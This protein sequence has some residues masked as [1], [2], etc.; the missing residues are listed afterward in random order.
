MGYIG[1]GCNVYVYP[2]RD[3]NDLWQYNPKTNTWQ[4]MASFPG[5]GR[6]SPAIFVIGHKAFVVTGAND[7]NTDTCYKGCW[8]Y[9]AHTNAWTQKADFPGAA[10]AGAVGFAIGNKGYMGMG[11]S[12]AYNAY[13]DFWEY[14][15]TTDGWI[16]KADFGGLARQY[17]S[18][19]GVNDKGY[20][21]FGEDSNFYAFNDIWEYD[22]GTNSWTQKATLPPARAGASGFVIGNNIYIGTGANY[23]YNNTLNDFWQYNTLNNT[24]RQMANFP[25]SPPR[26][27]CFS[28]AIGNYGYLGLGTDSNFDLPSGYPNDFYKFYPDT[29]TRLNS[30]TVSMNVISIYPNP[31]HKLLNLNFNRQ[32][33]GLATLSVMDITGKGMLSY[34]CLIVNEHL[35]ID[36]SSLTAGMY[37]II[38]NINDIHLT[39][40]FI[41]N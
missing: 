14:D 19:F 15:T 26:A 5:K 29:L 25:P 23:T 3:F 18:G 31:T 35:S 38:V 21:F 4:Q 36:I 28:F 9:D 10:R 11:K 17:A 32:L 40:K 12:S 2:E 24:W 39:Q 16:Q 34:K 7:L 20:V 8:E 37:F 33:H 6:V 22:T 27:A 41:K 30:L 1:L 13:K